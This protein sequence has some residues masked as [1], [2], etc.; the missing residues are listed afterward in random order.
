MM[1]ERSFVLIALE[2]GLRN[3][4]GELLQAD[5]PCVK[6]ANLQQSV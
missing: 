4:S 5:D 1:Y 3:P 2:P 6:R